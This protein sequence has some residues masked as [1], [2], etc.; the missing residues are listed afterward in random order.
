[1][2]HL[3]LDYIVYFLV[4]FFNYCIFILYIVAIMCDATVVWMHFC[5]CYT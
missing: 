3:L 5:Q 4:V 1:M 2:L